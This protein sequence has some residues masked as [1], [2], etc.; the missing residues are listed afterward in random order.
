M[1]KKCTNINIFIG[2]IG[3]FLLIFLL[4]F[5]LLQESIYKYFTIQENFISTDNSIINNIKE[6]ANNF[7]NPLKRNF[8][9]LYDKIYNWLEHFLKKMNYNL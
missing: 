3:A 4:I 7:I 2:F 6:G 1:K 8:R 5:L 9:L